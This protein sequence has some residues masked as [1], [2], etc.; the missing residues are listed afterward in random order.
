MFRVRVLP[1]LSA[2]EEAV[3]DKF[4]ASRIG[5]LEYAKLLRLLLPLMDEDGTT[6]VRTLT[7]N[8]WADLRRELIQK[9]GL[10]TMRAKT[11]I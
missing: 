10:T 11:L 5:D 9:Y 7:C 8:S 6:F 1:W 4:G 2:F 3:L